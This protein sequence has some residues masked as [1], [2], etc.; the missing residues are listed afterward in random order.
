MNKKSIGFGFRGWMV[1]IYQ[2]L[3]FI[4]YVTINNFGQNVMANVNAGVLGWNPTLVPTVYT[5]AII[6]SVV[7][8]FIFGKKIANSGKVRNLSIAVLGLAVLMTVFTAVYKSNY[9]VWLFVWGLSVLFS[10]IGSTFF[11]STIVGQWFPRR[12]GTVMGIATLAFPVINGVGLTVFSNTLKNA[13]GNML[14]AWLPWLIIDVIA[15]LICVVFIKEYPE[16][17]GAFPDNDRTMT[18]EIAKAIMEKQ[19]EARKKS[20]WNI[21]NMA[22]TKDFWLITIPQGILL[23]GS[24]GAMT[25]VMTIMAQFGFVEDH[26]TTAAGGVVFLCNAAIACLGSW[27]LGVLDTKFGTKFAI[28]TSGIF[29]IASGI[30]CFMGTTSNSVVIFLIGFACL[31]IFMGAS[32]NFTVSSAAQYWKREDFPSAFSFINPLANLI[33]AFGPIV[34]A[35]IGVA[36]GFHV[37]WIVI[38][39]LGVIA[40]ALSMAFKPARILACDKKYRKEAGLP[41]EGLSKSAA[42]VMGE[43]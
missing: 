12:K 27:I 13:H 7:L 35:G 24:I 32:S 11:V 19:I 30:L 2:F 36:A 42:E 34:V 41:E 3:A 8:Q 10:I 18:P 5:V 14:I 15:I 16:Q 23:L 37:V 40:T 28:V 21:K 4:C 9:T 17:C 1:L 38:G 6:V 43:K 33:S 26:A 22:R 31:Q 29:M 20:V 25:Q 39:I